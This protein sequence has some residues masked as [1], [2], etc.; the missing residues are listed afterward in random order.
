[1]APARSASTDRGG[2]LDTETLVLDE[3]TAR[4]RAEE[5]LCILHRDR[6]APGGLLDCD[7]YI[8]GEHDDPYMPK[9]APAEYRLLAKR[10]VAKLVPPAIGTPAQGL[11]PDGL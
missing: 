8:R 1:S 11:Y 7:R 6:S 3:E 5:L 4:D 9:D 2:L 10:C